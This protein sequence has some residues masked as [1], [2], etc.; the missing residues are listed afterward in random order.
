MVVHMYVMFDIDVKRGVRI[1]CQRNV[2]FINNARKVYLTR[3]VLI[4]VHAG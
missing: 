3:L 4:K 1:L 2:Q